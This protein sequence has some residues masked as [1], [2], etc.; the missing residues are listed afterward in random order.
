MSS[1]EVVSVEEVD[2]AVLSTSWTPRQRSVRLRAVFIL[3]V[4]IGLI[5]NLDG[6][7]VPA[8]LMHIRGTFDPPLSV[9]ELGLIGTLVYEGIAIGSLTV[10][11]MLAVVSPRRATQVTL[12]LNIIA[13]LC[14]GLATSPAM[15]LTFRFF[16]GFLQSIPAVYFPVWVDEFAP[17]D[18]A[19]LWMALVQTGAPLGIMIGY[20]VAGAL[21]GSADPNGC[22]ADEL[23]SAACGWR[24]PFVAQSAVLIAFS[25]VALFI[26]KEL[27]DVGQVSRARSH[28]HGAWRRR[29][30][31]LT[32]RAPTRIH[33]PS[34]PPPTGRAR[35]AAS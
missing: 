30:V 25:L 20:A 13:T 33:T 31:L 8:S 7:A 27:Y 21:T 32:S 26:P 2:A 17:P 6:G 23:F 35:P 22:S 14:F 10:G 1:A 9:V 11:P 15:L 24:I 3:L 12:V 16:I 5:I 4:L 18:K 29:R 19:A 34:N 28:R